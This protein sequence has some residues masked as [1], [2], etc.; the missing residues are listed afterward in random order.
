MINAVPLSKAEQED[1]SLK[2]HKIFKIIIIGDTG[3]CK[4]V[5]SA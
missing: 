2:P 4:L 1:K 5:V 3:K